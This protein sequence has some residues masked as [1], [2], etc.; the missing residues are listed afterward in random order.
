[1]TR[2]WSQTA[3]TALDGGRI[4][5]GLVKQQSIVEAD[6]GF[7]STDMIVIALLRDLAEAE[8]I[9][10]PDEP[11]RD[12]IG[13]VFAEQ[14]GEAPHACLVASDGRPHI[15]LTPLLALGQA[16]TSLDVV[17]QVVYGTADLLPLVAPAGVA[18]LRLLSCAAPALWQS[19][20]GLVVT[21][22]ND[23]AMRALIGELTL[24]MR[25]EWIDPLA[26]YE[27]VQV[28]TA[29]VRAAG[30]A[31]D[32]GEAEPHGSKL[33]ELEREL[34]SLKRAAL[35]NQHLMLVDAAERVRNPA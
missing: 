34:A 13:A 33:A 25:G 31:D 24:S 12:L 5:R 14:G 15:L 22:A 3:R 20:L 32:R 29:K 21:A 26:L 16:E 17:A 10:C 8:T 11:L 23:A 4:W 30:Q 6:L 2:S 28:L 9:V 1:M 27:R 19:G 18:G 35:V 7:R